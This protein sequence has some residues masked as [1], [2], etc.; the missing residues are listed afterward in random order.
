MKL[1]INKENV[2]NAI[3]ELLSKLGEAKTYVPMRDVDLKG[4]FKRADLPVNGIIATNLSTWLIKKDILIERNRGRLGIS[5]KLGPISID[6]QSVTDRYIQYLESLTESKSSKIDS[7]L[8]KPSKFN[9]GDEVYTM[10][11]NQL[12][13]T[14]ITAMELLNKTGD[15][16]SIQ[17]TVIGYNDGTAVR[18]IR[19]HNQLHVSIEDALDYLRNN[20]RNYNGY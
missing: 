6:H 1:V 16:M 11:N 10:D 4:I 17:Y 7:K 14:E 8:I 19:Y 9:L 20:L 2:S 5:W 15:E 13:K 18:A 3:Y 12:V